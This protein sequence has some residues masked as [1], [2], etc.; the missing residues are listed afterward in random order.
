M[1]EGTWESG[2]SS[3]QYLR[4]TVT[5]LI[6]KSSNNDYSEK[7]GR[8]DYVHITEGIID[9]E[10]YYWIA[11]RNHFRHYQSKNE[12]ISAMTKEMGC[13]SWNYK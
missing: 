9:K 1:E 3:N 4:Y 2:L 11:D 6:P 5:V 10:D 7:D 13:K 8:I 12:A